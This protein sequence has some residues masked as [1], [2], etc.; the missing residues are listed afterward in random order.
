M[1]LRETGVF[2]WVEYNGFAGSEG[3]YNYN[4]TALFETEEE[5]TGDGTNG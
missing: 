2:E 5:E 4:I 1:R 3:E